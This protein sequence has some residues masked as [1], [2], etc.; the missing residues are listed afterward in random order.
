MRF[1]VLGPMRVLRDGQPVRIGGPREHKILAMLLVNDG[2]PVP[3]ERLA[4][5]VWADDPP[6]TVHAQLHNGVATL[7]SA[8]RAGGAAAIV[9]SGSGFT[10]ERRGAALDIEDFDRLV[11]DARRADG[12]ARAADLYRSALA[13]W[14]GPAMDGLTGGRY[15]KAQARRLE[16]RRLACIEDRIDANLAAGR[17]TD[18]IADLA[19][20]TDEHPSRERLLA[21][22]MLALYR[23]GRR[24]DALVVF[25]AA[26]RRLAEETGLD[27]GDDVTDVHRAILRADP[28]L[29]GPATGVDAPPVANAA[30]AVPAQLP[31]EIRDFVGRA[32]A[33]AAMDA[34]RAA[35]GAGDRAACAVVAVTGPGGVGKTA[36]AVRWAW[37]VRGGFPDGQLYVNLRGFS[38]DPP[39]P[40]LDALARFLRAL[41]VPPEAVPADPD[42][43]GAMYRT[44]LVERRMLV[45]LDNARDAEHVRPLLPGGPDNVAVVTSRDTL[46][47]LVALDGAGRVRLGMLSPDEAMELLSTVLGPVRVAADA[48]SAADLTD[49]CGRLPLALRI[50]AA[51]LADEPGQHIAG[52]VAAL[53]ATDVL[54]SL[55]VPG[56]PHTSVR[57]AFELSYAR[58]DPAAR[59]LF[60]LAGLIPGADFAAQTAAAV[61]DVSLAQ[62]THLLAQLASAHLLARRSPRRYAFHDLLRRYAVE[63]AR[64]NDGRDARAAAT[65]RLDAHYLDAVDAAARALYPEKL[66]LPAPALS[67]DATPEHTDALDW[68]DAER[69]NLVAAIVDAARTGRPAAWLL[70]DGMRGYFFLRMHTVDWLTVARAAL[71]AAEGAMDLSGQA[72]AHLSLSDVHRRLG[73]YTPSV[74]HVRRALDLAAEGGWK[75]GEAVALGN[76]GNAYAESGRPADAASAYDQAARMGEQ[77]GRHAIAAVFLGN[78]GLVCFEMGRLADAVGHLRRALELNR[79]VGSAYGEAVVHESLGEVHHALGEPAVAE[80]HLRCA[81]ALHREL[82]DRGAEAETLRIVAE[83]D[84]DAGRLADALAHAEAALALGTQ[85][86]EPRVAANALNTLGHVRRRMGE[87]AA[88]A[89]HHR[90]ALRV[91]QG[92]ANRYPEVVAL[93]GIAHAEADGAVRG[94]DRA[95]AVAAESV[96]RLLEGQAYACLADLRLALGEP[97]EAVRAARQAV[98]IQRETGHRLGEARALVLLDRGLHAAGRPDRRRT[99]A[100]RA[101]QIF[102]AAGAAEA[103]G[104]AKLLAPGTAGPSAG[105]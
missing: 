1:E 47:G 7:R 91:A 9:R 43:A 74:E 67:T 33:L 105:A 73:R 40:V 11:A 49:V 72:A 2:M 32:D 44:L 102:N 104:V 79:Q 95:L 89:D 76:V 52:Y 53:R 16:E 98:A 27:F 84:A 62:A 48:A 87:P 60:R 20:L 42:E 35:R 10:I 86:G 69:S 85:T 55:A 14:R 94:V 23:C 103:E 81:L 5:V 24:S 4:A 82:G 46:N 50:A 93:L 13:L 38:T 12:P 57:T 99:A 56:E 25:V 58:V 83:L 65:A 61:G 39:L 19:M 21:M 97:E 100:R 45:V 101:L 80:D 92:S 31:A 96:Y 17:H 18:V 51:N 77:A 36:I 88:A 66:R 28:S 54:A 68:L 30:A 64:L 6:A 8:L 59:R 22:R 41:G 26:R 71:H 15:L 70:A 63:M 75:D 3:E 34:L 78:L 37:R 90:T 29:A